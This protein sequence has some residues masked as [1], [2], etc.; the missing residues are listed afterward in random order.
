MAAAAYRHAGAIDFNAFQVPAALLEAWVAGQ[1]QEADAAVEAFERGL[2]L[3]GDAGFADHA[4][5]A[6]SGLGSVAFA[7]GDLSA[8]A[9]LQRRALAAADSAQSAWAAAHARNE[10]ARV[11]TA[12]G[13]ADSAEKLYRNVIEWAETPR[14]HHA[15][16]SLFVALAGDPAEAARAGLAA[17]R[18]RSG[19]TAPV[20]TG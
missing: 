16:E 15:R 20:G 10:L 9:E 7:T 1:R 6:L 5:F 11:L 13:D 18:A 8:A 19:E 4:A 12:S 3:A 2:E 17:L 14:P